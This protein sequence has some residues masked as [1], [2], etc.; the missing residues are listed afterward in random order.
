MGGAEAGNPGTVLNVIDLSGRRFGGNGFLVLAQR[1]N[2]YTI[3]TNAALAQ[4]SGEDAGFGSGSGSSIGHRGL[5]GDP[6]LK[7]ASVTFLLVQAPDEP[8]PGDDLDAD[9]DGT[10]DPAAVGTWT[11]LD[12]VGVLDNGGQGDIAYGRINF[13][14]NPAATASGTVVNLDFTPGYV[15]RTGNTTGW[16]AADWVASA[17]AGADAD[18]TLGNSGNT[19]PAGFAGRALDHLG[20]PNF[21]AAAAHGVVFVESGRTTVVSEAGATDSFSVHLNTAPNG[22]VVIELT[23]TDSRV[24]I[25]TNNGATFG[26]RGI[27][28][29]NTTAARTVLVRTVDDAAVSPPSVT[30]TG[31]VVNTTAPGR[32]PLS[33]LIPPVEVTIHDNDIVVLN[34]VKVN[35]PGADEPHEFIELRGPPGTLLRQVYLVVLNGDVTANPGV[36]TLVVDLSGRFLGSSGLLVVAAPGHP[37]SMPEVG[38]TVVLDPRLAAQGGA[39]GNGTLSLL[40]VASPLPVPEAADLDKG[41]NGILEELPAGAVILDAVGWS[42]GGSQDVVYGG[43]ILQQ[44]GG[45]P[46][47]ATRFAFDLTPRSAA[48]W[49]NADLQGESGAAVLYDPQA[50]SADFPAGAQMSPGVF[51][52]TP[53]AAVRLVPLAGTIGDPTNPTLHFRVTDAESIP[54]GLQ[55]QVFS[56]NP[57]V[58]PTANLT[59]NSNG[60]GEWTLAADPVGVGYAH[61]IVR[62]NDEELAAEAVVPYAAS[63]MGR[64][65][66][67]FHYEITDGSAASAINDELMFVADDENQVI[68]IY[69]R[70]RS[71]PP[72]AG[73]DLGPFLGLTDFEGGAAREVDIEAATRVGDRIYWI[74]SHSHAEIGEIRTNRSRLFATDV[75]GSG[76]ASTLTY[77]GRYEH[78]KEDLVA[79]DVNNRHGRGANFYGL[80]ASTAEGVLPKA[81]DGSG[82]NI[83]GLC[84]APGSTN[85]AYIACR[86]PLV[87]A[88][89]RSRALLV[90]VLNFDTLAVSGAGPGAAQFGPPIELNLGC[91]G[92]RS[93]EG[94][95]N[96]YLIVAGPSGNPVGMPRHW[97]RLFTWTGRPTDAPQE[98][99][100]DLTGLNVEAIV[101][102]PAPP[103]TA[104]SRVQLISD[105]GTAVYYGDDVIGKLLPVRNF[106]KF[107]S[108]WV[109]LGEVVPPQP[110]IRSVR[111]A[112]GRAVLSWCALPGRRYRVQFKDDLS[113]PDWRSFPDEVLANDDLMVV[114]DIVPATGRRF[115]RVV[116]QP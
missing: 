114:E 24:Q 40:L 4:N 77:V 51:I 106:K 111:V 84:M 6:E 10:L 33:T 58:V 95:P 91:R 85:V 96:G 36:A 103:W 39:L 32:Y 20:L 45:T 9:N 112:G 115:Y 105:S 82:F 23:S 41:D 99:S 104:Q 101:D 26:N 63:A 52:N 12:S 43:V 1:T 13:R 66:G 86:A 81:I 42:D 88:T 110:L 65:N 18:L 74:G 89:N 8:E 19:A 107:R 75:A 54:S 37:Y 7:N 27:L 48:A 70:N 44:A 97:F 94:G 80:A 100:A 87:P 15:A 34:E 60:A 3:S 47:G 90:P 35:P 31:Q 30:I 55:V 2:A 14:R 109:E 61:L 22:R 79:W 59:L 64:D 16:A 38:T 113:E 102:L 5:D 73:V 72:L 62:V 57:E 50:A 116:L 53:P 25:S 76:A 78:L 56:D 46:D 28:S 29:L 93:I 92:V 71:G 17:V 108:D 21:G 98:L 83:E 67:R 49:F 11:I 68:R 69:E